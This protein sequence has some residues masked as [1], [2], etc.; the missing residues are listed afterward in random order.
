MKSLVERI[1]LFA[2]TVKAAF[3]SEFSLDGHMHQRTLDEL[4]RE[5]EL[6]DEHEWHLAEKP[7]DS[8]LDAYAGW[9]KQSGQARRTLKDERDRCNPDAS[10]IDRLT[11]EISHCESQMQSIVNRYAQQIPDRFPPDRSTLVCYFVETENSIISKAIDECR[12]QVRTER[13]NER[14]KDNPVADFAA[15]TERMMHDLS[16]RL[17]SGNWLQRSPVTEKLNAIKQEIAGRTARI[18]P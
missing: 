2:K 14:L 11:R 6:M 17:S 15:R 10:L 1:E 4:N 18:A 5:P 8:D 16:E 12:K 3:S 13:E 7:L 9:F